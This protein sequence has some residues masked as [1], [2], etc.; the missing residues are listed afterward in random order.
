MAFSGKE[1]GMENITRAFQIQRSSP[2]HVDPKN[3]CG[4]ENVLAVNGS[5]NQRSN[6]KMTKPFLKFDTARIS[7]KAVLHQR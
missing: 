2:V 3:Q 5:G 1:N 6:Q 4:Y 7:G